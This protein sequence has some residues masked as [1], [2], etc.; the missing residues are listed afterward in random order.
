M[1]VLGGAH[2]ALYQ[3]PGH[4]RVAAGGGA[5]L[6][7][8]GGHAGVVGP[9]SAACWRTPWSRKPSPAAM[10]GCCGRSKARPWWWREAT[11][12]AGWS[13][14]RWT[15]DVRRWRTGRASRRCSGGPGHPPCQR[16]GALDPLES[17][18]CSPGCSRT[19]ASPACGPR[20]WRSCWGLSLY[21]GS[22]LL[23]FRY[24]RGAWP[25]RYPWALGPAG[26]V[27][28][29][30]LG[31]YWYFDRG[32]HVPDGILIS[33][34]VVDGSPWSDVAPV[35][36]NVGLFATPAQGVFLQPRPRP[37]PARPGAGGRRRCGRH[38]WCCCKGGRATA[39]TYRWPNGKRRSSGFAPSALHRCHR[40]GAVT[41]N[42]PYRHRQPRFRPFTE[43]WLLIGGRGYKLGGRASRRCPE[44]PT[45]RG[46]RGGRSGGGR[47]SPARGRPVRP[48]GARG[49]VA[50]L[51]IP[52]RRARRRSNG[53]PHRLDSGRETRAEREDPRVT[54]HHFKL[55]RV[56]IPLGGGEEDL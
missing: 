3:G 51:G 24:G 35:H 43:C 31:G 56:A 22:L 38:R 50:A 55:F 5:R 53:L 44:T 10:A 20:C 36:S 28:A 7:T 8:A 18:M 16:H 41:R 19:S 17:G 11:A 21:I 47:G 2:F 42:L 52:G 13:T 27:L 40:V 54:A 49:P 37:D 34:T 39:S 48:T 29:W 12:R 9:G 4:R 1:V 45:A 33:S 30:A 26:L 25:S 14:W 15:W 23:W 6:E 46:S 32:G